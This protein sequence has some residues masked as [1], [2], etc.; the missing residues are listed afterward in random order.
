[1]E[2]KIEEKKYMKT[3]S[4]LILLLE[5]KVKKKNIE[6]EKKKDCGPRV[7]RQSCDGG[8]KWSCSGGGQWSLKDPDAGAVDLKLWAGQWFGQEIGILI[9]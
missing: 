5:R 4:E 2:R 3:L 6:A 1:M 7:G 8:M 9:G